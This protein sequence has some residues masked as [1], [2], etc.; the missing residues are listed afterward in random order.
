MNN[1]RV[2]C[3]NASPKTIIFLIA[4]L[5]MLPANAQILE[6]VGMEPALRDNT[7]WNPE[8]CR[9]TENGRYCPVVK[10]RIN[11]AD[12]VFEGNMIGEPEFKTN[13]YWVYMNPGAYHLAVKLPGH[14][15]LDVIF[16]DHMD[17][18]KL[19]ERCTY[20]LNLRRTDLKLRRAK[21]NKGFHTFVGASYQL[22]GFS[23]PELNFGLSFGPV[24]AEATLGIGT[25]TMD[26]IAIYKTSNGATTLHEA[27]NYKAKRSLG[28][29]VG[30]MADFDYLLVTPYLGFNSYVIKGE[31]LLAG[32]ATTDFEELKPSAFIA[33]VRLSFPIG[34]L[35]QVNVTPQFCFDL[36]KDDYYK[37]VC[38]GAC[39]MES[40]SKGFQLAGGIQLRF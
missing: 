4:L 35:V 13:E 18:A 20:I 23:G 22:M 40:W 14:D 36:G 24:Y 34:K 29:K 32:A 11:Q 39:D 2:H 6:V 8:T 26:N 7:A 10:V 16:R 12:C 28:F 19:K 3:S 33:G 5:F 30:Y 9:K 1:M 31:S 38:N 27:Y 17:D 21:L 25:N 37:V 15:F